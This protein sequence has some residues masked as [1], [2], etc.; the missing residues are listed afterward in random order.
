MCERHSTLSAASLT[1]DGCLA[2]LTGS[3]GQRVSL[4]VVLA[5]HA[6]LLAWSAPRHSPTQLEPA[7][8]AAGISNWQFGRFELFCVNP[9]LVR[10]VAALP[11]L[12]LGCETDW[13]AFSDAPG[14]RSEFSIGHE[15]I[16]ANGE[17]SL[18][19]FTWARWACIPFSLVGAYFASRWAGELYGGLAG[20]LTLVLWCFEPNLLAHAELITTDGACTSL[21]VAAGY[22]FWK[23]LKSPDWRGA[24]LAGIFLGL[25][26]LAKMSSLALLGLWPLSWLAWRGL[27]PHDGHQ[28][29]SVSA[30]CQSPATRQ[31][32]DTA[33]MPAA[34]PG[35][36][37]RQPQALQ[38][39]AMLAVSV[40]V[41][42]FGY[43]F[44]GTLT[45]LGEFTFVS[46]T[47]NGSDDREHPGNR[48]ASGWPAHVP[49]PLPRDFVL[50]FDL[51][52]RDFERFGHMSYLR[53]EWKQHSGWWYYYL[54]GLG[55]KVPCGDW[56]LLGGIIAGRLSRRTGA[57]FSR[58]EIVLLAPAVAL[59]TLVSSQTEF[60]IHLRYAFPAL[61]LTLV[62]LGQSARALAGRRSGL[63]LAVAGCI[64]WS[65]ASALAAY[66][67]HLAYFN[68]LAGGPRQGWRHLLGS[69]FDWGQDL[70]TV[71]RALDR[72]GLACGIVPP[73][74]MIY[75][76]APLGISLVR[77]ELPPAPGSLLAISREYLVEHTARP[78]APTVVP[79]IHLRECDDPLP[80]AT[81]TLYEVAPPA[82]PDTTPP[83]EIPRARL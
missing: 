24:A 4:V 56:L 30:P 16:K 43:A 52:K 38:L 1:V 37:P 9:P 80:V 73:P 55:V 36:A 7:Q 79:L 74:T 32:G 76:A 14:S 61:G 26:V 59:L 60:N 69:S 31:P 71:Q 3:R 50:G 42:N 75:D 51:Q 34:M 19:L 54:Y 57:R 2:W 72:R 5:V 83:R 25:A 21:T 39:A 82:T 46:Q 70:L 35:V 27:L 8:L 64:G 66:P 47:L 67:H 65:I 77:G 10:M 11:V 45:P 13:N 63:R 15:F 81:Y 22:T 53:G 48:F 40:Y 78:E 18:L 58:D 62:F 17:R 20:T 6:G 44:D 12:A 23:W 33:P 68:E 41:V 28:A 49:V 29:A